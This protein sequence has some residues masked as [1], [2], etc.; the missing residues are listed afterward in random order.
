MTTH[1]D[2][3]A[4]CCSTLYGHPLA[5]FLL[6]GSFHPGGLETTDAMAVAASIG[7]DHSVLDAGSGRG[8]TAVHLAETLGCHV[9]G[10]TLERE[11]VEEGLALAEAHGVAHRTEFIQGDL[12]QSPLPVERYDR[13]LMECVLSTVSDKPAALGRMR[14]ALRPDGQLALTDVTLRGEVPEEL[15]GAVETALCLGGAMPLET[16]VGTIEDAGFVVSEAT[17]LP[18]LTESFIGDAR[19][20]MA[21]VEIAAGLGKLP[22]ARDMIDDVKR[23]LTTAGAMVADG[24]LGYCRVVASKAAPQV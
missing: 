13:V 21:L 16:Y 5:T 19:K 10:L 8:T 14:D 7:R 1:L 6:G 20:R 24:S 3:I 15:T 2:P 9:T 17:E 12:L 11:G 4:A 22:V 18:G 23:A